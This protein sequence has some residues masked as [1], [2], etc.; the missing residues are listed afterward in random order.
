MEGLYRSEW[1]QAGPAG[2]PISSFPSNQYPP[3]SPPQI[4]SQSPSQKASPPYSPAGKTPSH[5]SSSPHSPP[6][7]SP[8]KTTPPS[9]KSSLNKISL[10]I[11]SIALII[12]LI[13]AVLWLFLGGSSGAQGP[14]G[15]QGA[16]G[17]Q[18][19]TI[20]SQGPQGYQGGPGPQGVQGQS[21]NSVIVSDIQA[22][23]SISSIV[24]RAT[25]EANPI[26]IVPLRGT[27][28]VITGLTGNNKD[29]AY[30]QLNQGDL[31]EGDVF[32]FDF[33]FAP[34]TIYINSKYY[35]G[36][37]HNKL[38]TETHSGNGWTMYFGMQNK[39]VYFKFTNYMNTVGGVTTTVP[40]LLPYLENYNN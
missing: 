16:I 1:P 17:P 3:F 30:I 25:S 24:G 36:F 26:S 9:K 21:G 37:N 20:G 35:N 14:Q 33:N 27:L 31:K 8:N 10:I 15:V 4:P 32:G 38:Y 7:S 6:S 19:P 11:A 13:V 12:M 39:N 34:M 18:G 28:F 22:R 40:L 29:N 23:Y 2:K 5:A